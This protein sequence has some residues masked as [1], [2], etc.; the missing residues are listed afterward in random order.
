MPGLTADFSG[1]ADDLFPVAPAL[2]RWLGHSQRVAFSHVDVETAACALFGIDTEPAPA[3]ALEYLADFSIPPEG[4]CLHLDPVHLRADT[5]GLLLFTAAAAALN[6]D[7][8]RALFEAVKPWLEN[9]GWKAH[10]AAADRWYV[11]VGK[12][13]PV[14]TT[15]PLQ[16]VI[17]QPVSGHLPTGSGAEDW[18]RCI[19]EMQMLLHGHEVNQERATHGRPLVN[20]LWLWGG[21]QMPVAGEVVYSQLYTGRRLLS[22]LADL[23]DTPHTGVVT[24]A[25]QLPVDQGDVLVDLK[26]CEAAAADGDVQRWCTALAQYEQD[27]FRPLLSLLLR[28]RIGRLELLPLDGFRYPL[29]RRDLLAWWRGK[30]DYRTL[31][32]V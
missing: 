17:G 3:A 2:S 15:T 23:H 30:A 7:E 19:N 8:G 9:D 18:L 1:Y 31:M 32:D 26:G 16:R 6:E 4:T 11:S 25:G 20:G 24:G 12:S 14:P 13:A 21:G 22:G 29:H 28:G 5:S 10:Y 27:W